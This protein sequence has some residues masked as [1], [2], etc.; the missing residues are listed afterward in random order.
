MADAQLVEQI[1]D[2]VDIVPLI[3]ELVPLKKR[4]ASHWGRCPF[5]QEKSPSF[6]VSQE[7]QLFHCFG[8]KA[9]GD[10]FKFV[11]LYYKWDFPQAV[12]ELAKRAGIEVRKHRVSPDWEESLEI[13]EQAGKFF[14]SVLTK[15]EKP[16]AYLKSRK[17]PPTQWEAFRLGAHPGGGQALLRALDEKGLS[18]DIAVRLGILMKTKSGDYYDRFR[19][20]LMFPICDERGRIRGFGGRSLSDEQPKYLNSPASAV[21]DKK[22]LLYGMHLATSALRRKEYA[23][24]VEGYL[25][26][27]SLHE[28]GLQNSVGS[29]GT[30]LT[31]EQVRQLKRWSSRVISLYDA[32]LAG[33]TATEKNLESFLLEGIEA[34]VVILPEAKDPD[35]FVHDEARSKEEKLSLLKTS[36]KNAK[37]SL[38]YLIEKRVLV[39]SDS[40]QRAKQLRSLVG[41]IDRLPDELERSMLKNE[42]SERFQLPR[43]AL[44][45]GQKELRQRPVQSRKQTSSS[46]DWALEVLKFIVFWGDRAELDL[47]G[48]TS[49]LSSDR[50]W[51]KL[52]LELLKAGSDSN[53]IASLKWLNAYP[54]EVQREIREWTI[55]RVEP[56]VEFDIEEAWRGLVAKLRQGYFLE[57]NKRLQTE[58]EKADQARD[59]KRVREL[60]V[61]KKDLAQL[62]RSFSS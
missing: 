3:S 46:S 25:D 54:E 52:L 4:G 38:D 61:E 24:L 28:F 16:K 27:I 45:L 35:A 17:I 48:L 11:Q 31:Q 44:G 9:G 36:F 7:K 19:G 26:V 13:L 55:G 22:R 43:E 18:R 6:S 40:L 53:S 59:E 23:I 58:L 8:C 12:E 30:A 57:E 14:E 39:E 51:S 15:E 42:I 41:M 20:R 37:R 33:M 49:Y 10:V 32:D 21:F 5:H 47:T 2:S 60:L 62:M 56:L 29:M 34:K 50:K 1:K